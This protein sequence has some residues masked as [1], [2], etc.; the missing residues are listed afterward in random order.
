MKVLNRNGKIVTVNILKRSEG[1]KAGQQAAKEGLDWP[2][3][4]KVSADYFGNFKAGYEDFLAQQEKEQ[5]QTPM[6]AITEALEKQ[7]RLAKESKDERK[8]RL[9]RQNLFDA[10][11]AAKLA[12]DTKNLQHFD[13]FASIYPRAHKKLLEYV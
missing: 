13:K 4:T 1:Y 12:L 2:K 11:D 9:L 3:I 6:Q 7:L 5:N 10:E 8:I